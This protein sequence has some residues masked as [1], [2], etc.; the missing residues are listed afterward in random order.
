MTFKSLSR[1]E[2]LEGISFIKTLKQHTPEE[3]VELEKIYNEGRTEKKNKEV[4]KKKK[5]KTQKKR[6]RKP[7]KTFKSVETQTEEP[8]KQLEDKMNY[9]KYKIK[10][11]K[12]KK[13]KL[14]YRK[15]LNKMLFN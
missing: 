13:E 10:H 8:N 11:T 9:L 14:M 5:V 1:R 7:K 6:G 4:Q 12:N 15:Q 2:Q 3:I